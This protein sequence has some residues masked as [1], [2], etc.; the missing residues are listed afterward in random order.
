MHKI[1]YESCERIK[2]RHH[3]L[4]TGVQSV[5]PVCQKKFWIQEIPGCSWVDTIFLTRCKIRY[6]WIPEKPSTRLPLA[7]TCPALLVGSDQN[8]Q[9][10]K[11]VN[12][13]IMWD[14]LEIKPGRPDWDQRRDRCV[15]IRR[16]WPQVILLLPKQRFMLP[17]KIVFLSTMET[18]KFWDFVT[19][20]QIKRNSDSSKNSEFQ[21][22]LKNI[23][24]NF[25]VER[26]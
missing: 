1:Q 17:K 16:K 24:Q 18:Q 4:P 22:S 8:R 2:C 11:F 14:D 10:Q 19:I 26:K 20:W 9:D 25:W 15:W 23:H 5:N 6:L 13:R 3:G 7:S 12:Q 21:A